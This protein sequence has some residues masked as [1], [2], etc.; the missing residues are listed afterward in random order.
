[1]QHVQAESVLCVFSFLSVCTILYKAQL[2][3]HM[4][5]IVQTSVPM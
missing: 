3:M 2:L 4:C 5:E 1:M